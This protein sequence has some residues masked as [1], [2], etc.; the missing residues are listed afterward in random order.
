MAL[1]S[2]GIDAPHAVV[3]IAGVV[4]R[5]HECADAGRGGGRGGVVAVVVGVERRGVVDSGVR[6]DDAGDGRD[7]GI[8]L[9]C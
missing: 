3:E 1:D 9:R 8:A 6:G 5:N 4:L 7:I 2:D